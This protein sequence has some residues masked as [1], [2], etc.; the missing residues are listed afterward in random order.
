M[1]NRSHRIERNAGDPGFLMADSWFTTC[2]VWCKRPCFGSLMLFLLMTCRGVYAADEPVP[3]DRAAVAFTPEQLN[4][5]EKE[6][7]PVLVEHCYKCHSSEKQSGNLRLDSRE[8]LLT[9]GESGAALVP[10]R[11]AD[12]VLISAINY[13]GYEMPPTGKLPAQQ[14]AALT[15]WVEMGAPW[16]AGEKVKASGRRPGVITVEDRQWW[17]FQPL[18]V[19]FEGAQPTPELADRIHDSTSQVIDDR[20]AQKRTEE[21]FPLAP[22]EEA[23]RQA[24]IRR[25]TFDL[26]GLPPTWEEVEQFMADSAPDAYERLVDRLLATPRYAERQARFWLD[27]VRYADSDGYRLDAAR[28]HVW[29]YR[30]YVIRSFADD[31][32]Y[33]RF[34]QE[35]LAG[36]ELFP[37]EPEAIVATGFLRH[38]I[39]E[40]N[41]RDVRTQWN[42]ILDDITDTTGDV[43]LG[44]GMQCARCHDHKFDPILQKDYFRL[45]SF[46]A[47]IQPHEDFLIPT[48][49]ELLAYQEKLAPWEAA[50]KS[51]REEISALEAKYRDQGQKQAEGRFPPDIQAILAKPVA[52]G[53]PIEKQLAALAFRQVEYEWER[54]DGRLKGADK[55][56]ILA[57]RKE[58]A[59]FDSI[60]PPALP[61]A[62][63]VTEWGVD[64]AEITIPKKGKEPIEPGFLTILD[65][66]PATVLPIDTPRGKSS[67]RRSTLAN[68]LTRPDHPLTARVMVN[69]IWQQHFGRGLAAN[70]S[71]FGRLGSLPT[72]P[73]LLDDLASRFV[74][75]GWRMKPLHKAIV[76]SETYRRS[77]SHPQLAELQKIDP[78]NTLYWRGDVRRLDA[79]QFRDSSYLVSGELSLKTTSG[80]GAPAEAPVRSIFLRTMRN[81]RNPVLDAFDAPF[82]ITSSAS[83]HSTTTPVQ[84]LLLFN[85]QWALQRAKGLAERVTKAQGAKPAVDDRQIITDLYRMT[86]GRD[87]E[88]FEIDAA[89]DFLGTQASTIN[90]AEATS[91]EAKFLHDKIPFR[92]GHAAV[93][94]SKQLPFI[95]P[96]IKSPEASDFTIESFFVVRSIYETG[97]VR[98]IAACWNGDMA[99]AGWNFGITGKGSRRK[100]QT[101]VMQMVGK[102]ADGKT[103]EAALFS[104]HHI[105]LNQ[106]YYAAAAVK[107]ARNGQPGQVTFY[108]KDLA[109]DDEPLLI[110]TVPHQL[111]GGICGTNRPLM[112]GGR[113]RTESARFDGLVDDVRMS[114]EALTPERLLFTS[115]TLQPST[116]AFWRFEP[117]PGPFVD[118]SGHDRHLADRPAKAE[119]GASSSQKTAIREVLVDFCHILL[120]SSEFMYVQ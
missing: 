120:N 67:G 6:V 91:A 40:Y 78:E 104:D 75:G 36:D 81:T 44:L 72:H 98:T 31:K 52:E 45:R 112:V 1:L 5:F 106:P 46:F 64:C 47:G 48:D 12:S 53:T 13:D 59:K 116:M 108:L 82:W 7:R 74:A 101:L 16:P 24:L 55:E 103:A 17:A 51:I 66:S 39:Y 79:E 99:E 56:R 26:T 10:H 92:D 25:V 93:V 4:F 117:T 102:T 54:L 100:P 8:F 70:A 65:A 86:L 113:D 107:L 29:R 49:A 30:D 41:S 63:C 114:A 97:A 111:V 14:I 105:Q 50:T 68:W 27:L 77:S 119:G 3:V 43:F 71:D 38:G 28:P 57:L 9:G 95:G 69:R 21:N 115:D 42:L 73:E 2:V 18:P 32:P 109:N 96:V 89:L 33:D 58:L 83:R 87:P 20:M 110:A 15:R 35:Q 61:L 76:L 84:S 118:A 62:T 11:P 22:A 94:S 37:H 60:K 90:I 19:L 80:P 34:V 23:S 88:S 85:S